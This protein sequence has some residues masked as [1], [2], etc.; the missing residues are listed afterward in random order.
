MEK[1]RECR[2]YKYHAANTTHCT[3][4]RKKNN[5]DKEEK[6][7]Q[8]QS[9]PEINPG[10]LSPAEGHQLIRTNP[11]IQSTVPTNSTHPTS[12]PVVE[13]SGL[14]WKRE[15]RGAETSIRGPK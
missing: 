7:Q 5:D 6:K 12:R 8:Q 14:V 13:E 1:T 9:C 3:A 4:R 10:P 2:K 15:I 11:I